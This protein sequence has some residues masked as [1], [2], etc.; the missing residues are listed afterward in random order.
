MYYFI[1]PMREEDIGQVQEIERASSRAPW[2]SNTYRRELR[3]PGSSRYLVARVSHTPPPPREQETA[4][5]PR[6]KSLLHV[7][8]GSFLGPAILPESPPLAGFGGLWLAV[9]E[10]HV[11]TINVSPGHRGRG[12][13]ELLLNGLIDQALDAGAASMTLEVRVSNTVA[14]NLYLK[15][16]FRPAGTRKRYYTDNGEDALIMW[17]EPI[18]SSDY[19]TRLKALRH[20]LFAHLRAQ[21]AASTTPAASSEQHR[22]PDRPDDNQSPR[23]QVACEP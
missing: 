7:L 3:N 2:S 13:G 21:A 18:N 19:Q 8:F 14:Q 17:T 11:T 1:E 4:R 20:R 22:R 9:D 5:P 10:A 23:D 12:I 16:G 6:S 15:Y